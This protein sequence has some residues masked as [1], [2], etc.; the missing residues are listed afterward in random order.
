MAGNIQE[1][2]ALSDNI[3]TTVDNNEISKAHKVLED[4]VKKQQAV[5][6]LKKDEEKIAAAIKD[7]LTDL[8]SLEVR[9]NR[10]HK[11]MPNA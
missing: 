1:I 4:P 7:N 5:D 11:D 3:E 2:K 8:I 9:W 6:Y 10:E